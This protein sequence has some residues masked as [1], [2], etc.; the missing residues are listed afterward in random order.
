MII[1][2]HSELEAIYKSPSE[3]PFKLKI[4]SDVNRILAAESA[5]AK[6]NVKPKD[7][8]KQIKTATNFFSES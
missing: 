2:A 5:F 4:V 7:S 8:K 3:I 6:K 1:D